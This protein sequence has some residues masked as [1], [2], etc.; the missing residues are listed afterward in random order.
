MYGLIYSQNFVT[1]LLKSDSFVS[2][3]SPARSIITLASSPTFMTTTGGGH[4]F[5]LLMTITGGACG[6]SVVVFSSVSSA[7]V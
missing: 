5:Y 2:S 6:F 1:C 3:V 7:D 4:T